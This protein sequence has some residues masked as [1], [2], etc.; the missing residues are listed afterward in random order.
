MNYYKSYA[1]FKINFIQLL[2]VPYIYVCI[3]YVCRAILSYLIAHIIAAIRLHCC[4]ISFGPCGLSGG[5]QGKHILMTI[6]LVSHSIS[7][8]LRS[9][10]FPELV[11]CTRGLFFGA[12]L[13]Q[14]QEQQEKTLAINS[15]KPKK[16]VYICIINDSQRVDQLVSSQKLSPSL[17]LAASR[18]CSFSF[19]QLLLSLSLLLTL[20]CVCF[21]VQAAKK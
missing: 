7:L 8:Q 12:G 14:Q 9:E 3:I 15:R 10:K 6:K 5:R 21:C 16:C 1:I 20:W 11:S 19:Q 4:H 17:S 2:A 13:K 18:T